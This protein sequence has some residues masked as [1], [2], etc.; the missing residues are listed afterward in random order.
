MP[1]ERLF[2]GAGAMHTV[3]ALPT[4]ALLRL[5]QGTTSVKL[6]SQTKTVYIKE[7]T[8]KFLCW[9]KN[10]EVQRSPVT[11]L[12]LIKNVAIR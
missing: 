3:E 11:E 12:N 9:E 4:A 10:E 8:I 7:S 5:P 6:A 2:W 1:V